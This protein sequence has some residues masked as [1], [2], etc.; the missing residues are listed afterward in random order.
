MTARGTV[1]RRQPRVPS[2]C[3]Y[4]RPCQRS[5]AGTGHWRRHGSSLRMRRRKGGTTY[6]ARHQARFRELSEMAEEHVRA[7]RSTGA[8]WSRFAASASTSS[9]AGLMKRPMRMTQ[10]RRHDP[11]EHGSNASQG[12]SG[13]GTAPRPSAAEQVRE[14]VRACKAENTIRGYQRTGGASAAGAGS[15][16]CALSRPRRRR[17]RSMWRR[18][19]SISRR[20]AFNAG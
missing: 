4:L 11:G 15:A 13:L 19:A 10:W 1:R 8:S 5:V 16:A 7:E 12:G 2:G 3:R 20:A 6:W 17:W 14:F 18:R 9:R